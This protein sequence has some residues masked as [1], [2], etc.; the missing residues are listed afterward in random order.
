VFKY[1]NELLGQSIK[2]VTRFLNK[3]QIREIF[4]SRPKVDEFW[5]SI[6]QHEKI[7]ENMTLT[8]AGLRGEVF[9]KGAGASDYLLYFYNGTQSQNLSNLRTFSYVEH[10]LQFR[11]HLDGMQAFTYDFG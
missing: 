1:D 8:Y 10:F 6:I 4:D 3:F 7:T 5:D 11:L 9:K 2:N